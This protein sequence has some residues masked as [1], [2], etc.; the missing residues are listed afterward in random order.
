MA[1]SRLM[2]GQ[3]SADAAVEYRGEKPINAIWHKPW[4][5]SRNLNNIAFVNRNIRLSPYLICSKSVGR[6]V[7]P[8]SFAVWM[9]RI[10]P[11]SAA[12]S[13]PPAA[14]TPPKTVTP[15]EDDLDQIVGSQVIVGHGALSL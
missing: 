2:D 4:R 12:K 9:T 1:L 11:V 7:F 8:P 14:E 5:R 10:A 6:K 15:G 13:G 3:Q